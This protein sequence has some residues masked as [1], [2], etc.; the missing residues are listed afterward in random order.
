MNVARCVSGPASS[1][2][3]L[4][5]LRYEPHAKQR[6]VHLSRA[7]FR[8]AVAGRQSGK[9]RTG[10]AEI[11][12]WAMPNDLQGAEAQFWWVTAS[13]RTK[14]KAWRDLNSHIPAEYVVKKH[15]SGLYMDLRNSSRISIR[16][17]DAPDSL[18]SEALHGL[19]GDEF[20]Q[21]GPDVWP[22]LL[23]PMLTTTR[24]PALFA[25]TPRGRNW[26]YDLYAR[27][28][29]PDPEWESFR[30]ASNESPYFSQEEFVQARMEMPERI[31]RQEILAEFLESGGEVFRSVDQAISESGVVDGYTVLGVDLARLRDWTVIWAM[32]S[33]REWVEVQ[34]FQHMDWSIQKLKIIEAYRRNKCR[35]MVIDATGVGDPIVEDLTK[36]G[37]NVEPVKFSSESKG[38]LIENLM[39]MFDQGAARI[40]R[41]PVV[42]EEHKSF[43]FETLPSGRDRFEAPEGR[44]DDTVI[45]HALAAWGVRQITRHTAPKPRTL[46][47]GR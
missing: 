35:K 5:S 3:S 22:M 24:G 20:C 1:K 36:A 14:D 31:F 41:D 13:Y 21:W 45:A 2:R 34:R 19:I 46:I 16:S 4:T 28:L 8:V 33:A 29:Q 17:A 9:T 42:I 23:R 40:P 38:L 30:W 47:P 37:L 10:V 7:R 25:G 43:G 32:N 26:G 15:E 27:G 12:D 39:M 44:H 18:V 6:E 11:A